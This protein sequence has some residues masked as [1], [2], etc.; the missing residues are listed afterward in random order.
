MGREPR[1]EDHGKLGGDVMTKIEV[2]IE[3]VEASLAALKLEAREYAERGGRDPLVLAKQ[4]VREAR[5]RIARSRKAVEKSA[6]ECPPLMT[7][8][9]WCC[10]YSTRATYAEAGCPSCGA[11]AM[12]WY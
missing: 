8:S 10:D 2:L 12:E 7:G 9:C 3:E 1:R 11:T 4:L 5:T 6:E